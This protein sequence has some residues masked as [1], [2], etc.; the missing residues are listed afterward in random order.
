MDIN[1]IK[2]LICKTF[3][4]LM[5]GEFAFLGKGKSGLLCIANGEIVFKIPLQSEGEIAR[6]QKNEAV[7]LK[8]LEGKLDVDIPKVLYAATAEN[9]LFIFGET[10][11][12]GTSLTYEL[13]DT[14]CE[15][16]KNDL[17]R[18]LGRIVR[19][20]HDAG[21]HD[22]SWQ[23]DGYQD[24]PA[25]IMAEFYGRFSYDVRSVFSG[26]EVE[27]ICAIAD[28]YQKITEERPVR[29]VLCHH[30]LHLANLMIDLGSKRI[31]GLLDFGCA[32]Y[33]EPARDWHY[34]FDSRYVLEGYGGNGDAYFLD[35]QKFHALSWL[36][37]NLGEEI[38]QNQKPYTSL[39]YIKDYILA[40]M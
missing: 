12:C 28:K 23:A 22:A 14:F 13:Y 7:V 29:P 24:T 26:G 25:E 19:G 6:W 33:A 34:Y 4:E 20:L 27:K 10:F 38:G 9:G 31:T 15:D 3:P 5:I 2:T 17:L 16:T 1:D 8:Y 35:R 40:F 36:L 32:G 39:G 30:D 37:H 18:Q 11:L 21:G